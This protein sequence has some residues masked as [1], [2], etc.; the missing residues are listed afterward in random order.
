MPLRP[1]GAFRSGVE[2]LSFADVF[3]LRLRLARTH[4]HNSQER[5]AAIQ[6]FKDK[7]AAWKAQYDAAG[8]L[9]CFCLRLRLFELS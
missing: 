3:V 9:F 7:F 5:Q 4:A 1:L 6:E 8:I 2:W